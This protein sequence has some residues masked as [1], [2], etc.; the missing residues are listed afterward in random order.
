MNKKTFLKFLTLFLSGIILVSACKSKDKENNIVQDDEM[1]NE[2]IQKDA[3]KVNPRPA[4]DLSGKVQILSEEEF[5]AKITEIDNEKGFQY[6][7]STPAIVDFYADWCKPCIALGPVLETLGEKYKGE[8]IVYKV[9][10]DKA[11]RLAIQF[12]IQSVPSLLFLK[13]NEQPRM[14]V[15]APS[16]DELDKII[17]EVLL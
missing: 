13:P 2:T 4:E 3:N 12:G 10:V 5:I 16:Q 15:G 1:V 9:N 14:M 8:I 7:G 17:Q 11:Q 6:K